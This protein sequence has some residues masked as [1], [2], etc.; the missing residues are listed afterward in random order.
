VGVAAA[1][2]G[3]AASLTSAA[4]ERGAVPSA[5]AS[6]SGHSSSSSSL[7]SLQPPQHEGLFASLT[8]ETGNT[9]LPSSVDR[10]HSTSPH[11]RRVHSPPSRDRSGSF[12]QGGFLTAI[13][14]DTAPHNAMLRPKSSSVSSM[15]PASGAAAGSSGSAR[16]DASPALLPTPDPPQPVPEGMTRGN[17]EA[18]REALMA[19]VADLFSHLP[20]E[21]KALPLGHLAAQGWRHRKRHPPREEAGVAGGLLVT[22]PTMVSRTSKPHHGA[23]GN[24]NSVSGDCSPMPRPLHSAAPRRAAS[25][26][27]GAELSCVLTEAF[28]RAR[29]QA[30]AGHGMG[31]LN[32][33]IPRCS[34]PQAAELL[35]PTLLLLHGMAAAQHGA[36]EAHRR[37]RV[38]A[39]PS[40]TTRDLRRSDAAQQWAAARAAAAM[41]TGSPGRRGGVQQ[42]DAGQTAIPQQG[43]H[44]GQSALQLL[45]GA[46]LF[47]PPP[48]QVAVAKVQQQ[49]VAA[50]QGTASHSVAGG[51]ALLGDVGAKGNVMRSPASVI[52]DKLPGDSSF[53]GS[54]V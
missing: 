29:G 25:E 50:A 52:F 37:V 53:S 18:T 10:P 48:A 14:G 15:L 47:P 43:Q 16:V 32:V 39:N 45:S 33:S 21:L 17:K 49:A 42:S 24:W 27:D 41:A 2:R 36:D 30:N 4:G 11:D 7:A 5:V 34:D 19:E 46:G 12:T 1:T 3:S 40:A 44:T 8:H 35:S 54:R 9:L 20:S 38:G 6:D 51:S 26:A 28:R 22:A 31:K 13:A 23:Y